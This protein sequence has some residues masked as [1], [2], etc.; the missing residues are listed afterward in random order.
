MQMPPGTGGYLVESVED[1]AAGI[2]KLLRDPAAAAEL[3]QRG[4]EHVR[5]HFLLPRLLADEL[6]LLQSVR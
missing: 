3:G 1:C 2:L 5:E 4:R 6:L